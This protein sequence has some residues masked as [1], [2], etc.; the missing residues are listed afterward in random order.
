MNTEWIQYSQK[1][2]DVLALKGS[3][4][5]I[6]YSNQAPE[7]SEPGKHWVCKAILDAR[8]GKIINLTRESSAC[9]GGKTYL[10]L[11]P[12]PEGDA[13][14]ALQKFLVEGEK[15]FCSIVA[16]HRAQAYSTTPPLGLAE[17]VILWPLERAEMMPDLVLFIVNPEQA[18]RLIQLAT[19]WDGIPPKTQMIGAGCHQAVGYPLVSGEI[20]VTFMD[21]TARRT[22]P[23]TADELI[24]SVPYHRLHGIVEAIDR[25]TAGTA[26]MEIPDEFRRI[27]REAEEA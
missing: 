13:L 12:R 15:L 19:Y 8:D 16:F 1:L 3:P 14:R 25:S 6:T 2:R 11:A 20:N 4:V 23:Y 10:G 7:H 21:W 18:A 27:M 24:V 17:N 26:K 5:A 22:K 9:A